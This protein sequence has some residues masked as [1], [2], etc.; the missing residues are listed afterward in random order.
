MHNGPGEMVRR[1][2]EALRLTWQAGPVTAS[3]Y[4]LITVAEG[5]LP[6][7]VALLTKWLIDGIQLGAAG[8]ADAPDKPAAPGLTPLQ[9]V[10]WIGVLSAVLAALPPLREFWKSRLQRGVSLLV[11]YRLYSA[12]S[13][14]QGL[15]RFERPE[16]LDRLRMAQQAATTAPEQVVASCFGLLQAGLTVSS[17]LGV[18]VSI[19]PLMA[20]VTVAAVVPALFVQLSMSR[21]LSD[22][23]WEMS[24]RSRRQLFYQ[25]MLFD[26]D[27]VKETRLFGTGRF[28]LE[29]MRVETEEI[30]RAE[31]ALDRRTVVRHGPLSV[32]GALVAAGGLVWIVVEATEGRLSIGDV[33][34]FIAAV[35]GVQG[36][37]GGAVADA[38][39]AYQALLLFGHYRDVIRAE[40]D[41]PEPARPRGLAR[42]RHGIHLEDVWFRYTDEGPW[43]LRGVTLTIPFGGSLALVGLNGA[44]KSTLVKLLCRMYDP[45][46]GRILWDGVD[47]REVAVADLR[48]RITA[49]FQDFTAYDLTVQENIGIGDVR[50]LDDLGKVRAAAEQ[51][52][53]HPVV[54]KLPRGY[55]SMLSR[56]F[57][58]EGESGE[59]EHG[60]TLSGGQWQRIALARAFVRTGRDLLIL[61]EPS[62]GLDPAAEREVHDSLRD[63]RS[64]ATSVLISHRLGAVRQAD[65]IVVLRHG[66]V[67]EEGTHGQLL[68]KDGEYARLYSL[69]ASSYVDAVGSSE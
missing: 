22:M 60:V 10:V 44:G 20:V 12:V 46:K 63:Y 5:T 6:A 47:I 30:N 23:M 1:G 14:L 2:L 9:A 26:L 7:A 56:I 25:R 28:L 27:A 36:S 40:P 24:P 51:A 64:D 54:E 4:L 66:R 61:D 49:V 11:Q 67:V 65:R 69:Q 45:T 52:G 53:I 38:T 41:L 3:L 62:S 48:E 50:V 29:R 35:A 17:F 43:V 34:A 18:L 37:L 13:R 39:S 19:S 32:L 15:A 8:S 68:R 55:R 33:A 16:F 21:Q 57:Y 42:L 59:S 31:E 58:Q